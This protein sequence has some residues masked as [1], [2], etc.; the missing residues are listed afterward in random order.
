MSLGNQDC[1]SGFTDRSVFSLPFP[2]FIFSDLYIRE[3]L[4]VSLI[5]V[6]MHVPVR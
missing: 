6:F 1:H 4:N 2:D 3:F 5:Y